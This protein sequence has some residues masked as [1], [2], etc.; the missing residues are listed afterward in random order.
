VLVLPLMVYLFVEGLEAATATVL[1]LARRPHRT[2]IIVSVVIA[3]L[4]AASLPKTLRE[5]LYRSHHPRFA[6]IVEDGDLARWM[7]V[8]DYLR[9]QP[10]ADDEVILTPEASIVHW[11]SDRPTAE[12]LDASDEALGSWKLMRDTL[13]GRQVRFVVVPRN[14]RDDGLFYFIRRLN[15]RHWTAPA[16]TTDHF[17]VYD[18][19]RG[20][21]L[22]PPEHY[23]MPWR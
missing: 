17:E 15:R 2:P 12:A 16:L 3:M 23:P 9:E 19:P 14:Y 21:F 4:L 7:P 10:M 6:E 22:Y 8:I 5:G 13:A 18:C 20:T 1:S 11:L